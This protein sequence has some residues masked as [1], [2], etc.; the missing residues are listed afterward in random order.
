[1]CTSLEKF[2]YLRAD[3][4]DIDTSIQGIQAKPYLLLSFGEGLFQ[5]LLLKTR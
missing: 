1:M 2:V 5:L 4:S 3:Y